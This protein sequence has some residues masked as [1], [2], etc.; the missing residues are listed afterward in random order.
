[1]RPEGE[2]L[3]HRLKM[4]QQQQ[5]QANRLLHVSNF[6]RSATG[7]RNNNRPNRRQVECPPKVPPGGLVL[8]HLCP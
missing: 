3:I 4:Q 5:Q 8:F 1:M 7:Q 2:H 6:H